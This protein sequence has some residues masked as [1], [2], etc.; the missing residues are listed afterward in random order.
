MHIS[1]SDCLSVLGPTGA[2]SLGNLGLAAR[3]RAQ[4]NCRRVSIR[5]AR[6]SGTGSSD[7]GKRSGP[8]TVA[9]GASFL[10]ITRNASK[11]RPIHKKSDTI[12]SLNVRARMPLMYR[13]QGRIATRGATIASCRGTRWERTQCGGIEC[14]PRV[15]H[16]DYVPR[17]RDHVPRHRDVHDLD[18]KIACHD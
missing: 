9:D 10:A 5:S 14:F 11:T 16:R 4:A 6:Q 18:Q 1:D 2:P 3:R 12:H 13:T 7:S 15:G 8:L 17:H